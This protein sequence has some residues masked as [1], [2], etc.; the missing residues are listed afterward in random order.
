MTHTKIS[1][2]IV[3]SIL[4]KVELLQQNIHFNIASTV[5]DRI[6]EFYER[7][8]TLNLDLK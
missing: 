4:E 3:Q 2:A 8:P 7:N 1:Y 5:I 6:L